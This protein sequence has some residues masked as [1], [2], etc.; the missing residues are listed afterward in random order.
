M[1]DTTVKKSLAPSSCKEEIAAHSDSCHLGLGSLTD[2][3]S[4]V[5]THVPGFVPSE[6]S[7]ISSK[8]SFQDPLPN[9][10]ES[11]L[12][13]NFSFNGEESRVAASHSEA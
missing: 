6:L 13:S 8:R 11:H 3:Q 9:L 1:I 4:A 10:K 5:S 12:P 2:L 7:L